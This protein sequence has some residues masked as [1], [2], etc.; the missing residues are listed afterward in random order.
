MKVFNVISKEDW[1]EN[2]RKNP[3]LPE[4]TSD[5]YQLCDDKSKSNGILHFNHEITMSFELK[6]GKP[7]F[8]WGDEIASEYI[9][10]SSEDWDYLKDRFKGIEDEVS[11][12]VSNYR[13]EKGEIVKLIIPSDIT[14]PFLPSSRSKKE[15]SMNID[16][17]VP[18]EI[19]CPSEKDFPVA[20]KVTDFATVAENVSKEDYENMSEE[21]KR[22]L[23][24]SCYPTEEIR[25]LD[26]KLYKPVHINL[27]GTLNSSLYESEP[28]FIKDIVSFYNKDSYENN[29]KYRDAIEQNKEYNSE[30]SIIN[31]QKKNTAFETKK[32]AVIND[33][34]RYL[35]FDN[36][37][38]RECGEPYYTITG[39]GAGNNYSIGAFIDYYNP[40][41]SEKSFDDT[42][43]WNFSAN[44]EKEFLEEYKAEN[45]YVSLEHKI[46]TVK[47]KIEILIPEAVKIKDFIDV[48]I[49]KE[50]ELNSRLEVIA[51]K[52]TKDMEVQKLSVPQIFENEMRGYFANTKSTVFKN[53]W[54][55]SK[56]IL[57]NWTD[58]KKSELNQYFSD[59]GIKSKEAFY[60]YFEETFGIQNPDK[61]QRQAQTKV[62]NKSN[63]REIGR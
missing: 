6:E 16:I 22:G 49:E 4:V 52:N 17:E 5:V 23:G 7:C 60:K 33:A 57:A 41:L 11:E 53:P 31:E 35:M 14:V 30:K 45:K 63:E 21:K 2:R 51:E 48:A 32:T 59:K 29:R 56:V 18:V 43:N 55:A 25:I 19:R 50:K 54:I 24:S 3:E 36:K 46:D 15:R 34:A 40:E 9:E 47:E 58:E 10:Y 12:A 8:L 44:H 1:N 20:F 62:K 27:Y 42:Y 37:I 13:Q 39:F 28:D 26:G 61:K 38:W